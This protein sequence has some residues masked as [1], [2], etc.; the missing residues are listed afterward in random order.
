MTHVYFYRFISLLISFSL[1]VAPLPLSAI[2]QPI[3]A[4]ETVIIERSADSSYVFFGEEFRKI[5][6]QLCDIDDANHSPL[7]ELDS[8]MKNGYCVGEYDAVMH[9]LE[10]AATI[11]QKNKLLDD[12]QLQKITHDLNKIIDQILTEELIVNAANIK[13]FHNI[14][15]KNLDA[16]PEYLQ[17]FDQDMDS[18][19]ITRDLVVQPAALVVATSDIGSPPAGLQTIDGVTLMAN[20]RVL[21]VGQSNPIENGLWLAASGNWTRPTDFDTGNMADQAYVFISSGT[22]DAGTSW[23]C[24]TPTAVIDT[25]PITF[26]LFAYPDFNLTGDVTGTQSATVVSLV[27]GQT[28]ANVALATIAALAAT[29]L[30]TVS[31]LVE[32]DAS[33]NFAAEAISMTDGVMSNS[34]TVTPFSSAGV[35]HNNSSGR[36]SSS[37]IVNADIASGA[38]IANSKLATLTTAGLVA[39]AATTANSSNLSNAIVARD[40]NGNFGASTITATLSGNATSATTATTAATATNFTGSLIGDVTGTQGATTVSMVGGQSATNVANATLTVQSAASAN[41]TGTIVKRS[42]VNGFSAGMISVTDTVISNT[43]TIT[44]FTTAGILHNSVT[45]GAI[46]SSLIVN[47]DISSTAA[48]ANS[49]LATLTTAGLVANSATTAVTT[50][51]ANTIV[52]RDSSANVVASSFIGSLVGHASSDLLLTG[53]TLTGTLQLPAGTTAVP[54]LTF[55]GS[56]TAG[57]S[58]SSGNLSFSTNAL[59]RMKISSGGIVSIPSLTSPGVIHNDSLGDLSSSLIVDSDVAAGAAIQNGKLATLTMAGLVLNSATSATN[60]NVSNAIVSR[61]PS[62]NFSAQEVSMNDGILAGNLILSTDPSTSTAGCIFKGSTTPF[63]HNFGTNNTFVG[64]NTGNFTM[65]GAQNSVFGSTAFT[66]NSS[67]NNNTA[68]G[69]NT[70]ALCTTAS[71]NIA[72]GY[73]AGGTLTSGS[74]NIYINAGANS[75]SEANTTRIGTSQTQCFVAGIAGVTTSIMDAVPVLISASTGQLGTISSSVTRKHNIDDMDNASSDIYKLR[76]V[77]FVYNDDES[78]TLQYGLIAE[79]ADQ[80]FPGIVVRNDQGQPETIQYHV[81]PILLLNEMKKQQATIE[82]MKDVIASL[83]EQIQEFIGRV[84]A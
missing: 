54:S 60:S 53:G 74:G 68:I 19:S 10:Y 8:H 44:P 37:L 80:T 24:T 18:S 30:N 26:T 64:E 27:G 46:S 42:A 70:L 6:S 72:I 65:T 29:N 75:S 57:L 59:A 12:L 14:Q 22:A 13:N 71:N 77:T 1:L 63:I 47:A 2:A 3:S 33:G 56:T 67:G 69:Y 38:A 66:S 50:A 5:I 34:L 61:D 41:N 16:L 20:N 73:D 4:I 25:D 78:N 7:H 55:T 48:I 23:L 31:T 9:V 21:L 35:V 17:I 43:F 40:I 36:L 49:K 28:A 58:A 81:L 15:H 84:K 51:T 83:Q 76:P 52:L 11:I 79:E 45:T 39:N 62:G 32:R 82:Q